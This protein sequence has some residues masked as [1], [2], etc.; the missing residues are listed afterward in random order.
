MKTSDLL[1][2]LKF[3]R[4]LESDRTYHYYRF[5]DKHI[6]I[7]YYNNDKNK[8]VL[9]SSN[10]KDELTIEDDSEIIEYL[11]IIFKDQI[12]VIREFKLKTLL[13]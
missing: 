1:K 7:Y 13:S 11:F 8:Y 12:D 5:Y 9:R 6:L 10:I 4:N 3:E 2:M